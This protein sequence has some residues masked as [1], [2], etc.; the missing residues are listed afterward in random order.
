VFVLWG[1]RRMLNLVVGRVCGRSRRV[2]VVV[3]GEV[4]M[5]MMMMMMMIVRFHMCM[6]YNDRHGSDYDRPPLQSLG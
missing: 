6:F 5:M 4:V 2:V 3:E 1:M